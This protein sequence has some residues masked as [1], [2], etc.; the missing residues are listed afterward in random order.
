MFYEGE[1]H[2][3]VTGKTK[4]EAV[5]KDRDWICDTSHNHVTRVNQ[6]HTFTPHT[7]LAIDAYSAIGTV[8]PHTHF[9]FDAY[10]AISTV[11]P[12]THFAIDAYSAIG[13]GIASCL[14]SSS[15]HWH[16][17]MQAANPSCFSRTRTHTDCNTRYVLICAGCQFLVFPTRTHAHRLYC[18]LCY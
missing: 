12:H 14:L 7:H 2:L 8:T 18:S 10:S 15:L 5:A 6:N 9:A 16:S 13:T 17:Y 4:T 11:T 3:L 1:Q